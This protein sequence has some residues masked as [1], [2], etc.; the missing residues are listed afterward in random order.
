M[1]S[2]K[3]LFFV[4]CFLLLVLIAGCATFPQSES[5]GNAGKNK[6]SLSVASLLKFEDIPVPSGFKLL[7]KESFAFQNDKSRVA[8]LKYYGGQ[9]AE[10]V[11][12][13]YKAQMASFNW[14]LVN[15]IEYDRKVLNYENSEESC[16]ITIQP[17]GGKSMV[18]VALS[19]KSR[20]IKP[21]K[22]SSKEYK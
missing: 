15:I 9:N 5:A 11:L 12:E 18:T 13:F 10:K 22:M 4:P 17:Q 8:L 20:P 19:P 7:D 16:I 14:S 6:V 1:H 2:L 21:E 3:P